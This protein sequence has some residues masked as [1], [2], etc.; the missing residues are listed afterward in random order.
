MLP[1]IREEI[2][3]KL[4]QK[5]KRYEQYKLPNWVLT[6]EMIFRICT[7]KSQPTSHLL[8]NNS[9]QLENWI[10][11]K[12]QIGHYILKNFRNLKTFQV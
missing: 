9:G 1:E 5:L 6:D 7:S 4:M 8:K 3:V 11:S 2:T 10:V 12:L